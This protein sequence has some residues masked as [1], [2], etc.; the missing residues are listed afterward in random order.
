M[1]DPAQVFLAQVDAFNAA[2]LEAFLATYAD[3]AVVNGLGPDPVAGKEAL[4]ALY[5]ERFTQRPLRCEVSALH[6]IG[7]RWAVAHEQVTGPAGT[8]ELV[9]VFEV[10]D[11]AIVRAD[12]SARHPVA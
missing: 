12:M 1:P 3:D 9:A 5:A 4:R 6:E 11:G 7:G 10:A 8:N 2:D